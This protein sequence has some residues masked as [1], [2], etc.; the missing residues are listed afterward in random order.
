VVL[1][2]ASSGRF[3]AALEER[4]RVAR[5]EL[6]I[7]TCPVFEHEADAPE[8][9]TPGMAGGGTANACASGSRGQGACSATA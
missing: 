6:D 4:L 1:T 5:Q 8:V 7:F 9:P 2:E 3:R